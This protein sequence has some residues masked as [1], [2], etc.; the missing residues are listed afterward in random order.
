LAIEGGIKL[1]IFDDG[2]GFLLNK[3]KKGIG[4]QN[5]YSRTALCNGT[6]LLESQKGIGTTLK[7]FVPYQD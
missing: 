2:V 7:L 1:E 4:L 5:I 3:K 6:V